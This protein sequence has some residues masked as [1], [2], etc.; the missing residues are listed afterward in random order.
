M[1]EI[2]AKQL[3]HYPALQTRCVCK[4]FQPCITP[5]SEFFNVA[6]PPFA[7]HKRSAGSRAVSFGILFSF[8]CGPSLLGMPAQCRSRPGGVKHRT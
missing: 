3:R 1:F 7:V 6:T 4:L 8:V 5:P 2:T